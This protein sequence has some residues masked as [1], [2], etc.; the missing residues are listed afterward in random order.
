MDFDQYYTT[1]I[2]QRRSY[3]KN[4][5]AN[6]KYERKSSKLEVKSKSKNMFIKYY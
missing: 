5:K 4:V 2:I 6:V 3:Y 1:T